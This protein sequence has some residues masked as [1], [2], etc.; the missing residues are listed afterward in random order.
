M[1]TITYHQERYTII[2]K[3][4]SKSHTF[5]CTLFIHPPTTVPN[6]IH[7]YEKSSSQYTHLFN[8]TCVPC[9]GLLNIKPSP[10]AIIPIE[11]LFKY[12][13]S[14]LNIY[15]LKTLLKTKMTRQQKNR[16]LWKSTKYEQQEWEN[17]WFWNDWAQGMNKNCE[18]NHLVKCLKTHT[19]DFHFTSLMVRWL[20][21][22][23]VQSNW[24][25]IDHIKL[26][27]VLVE[28]SGFRPAC[29][30]DSSTHSVLTIITKGNS[31]HRQ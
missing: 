24:H 29:R 23:Y 27:I 11:Y 9:L 25:C 1:K 12:L 26:R 18:Y 22:N 2:F 15:S 13:Q 6:Y 16:L 14:F 7:T 21:V 3:C 20:T 31:M 10:H 28:L 8:S 17:M 5:S 19:W 4:C 30:N